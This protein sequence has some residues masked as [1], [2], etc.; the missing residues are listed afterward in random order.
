MANDYAIWIGNLNNEYKEPMIWYGLFQAGSTAA[1]DAGEL[2]TRGGGTYFIPLA[3]DESMAGVIAF[4][5]CDIVAGDLLGY[6]PIIVPRPGDIFKVPI[7]TQ[8]AIALGTSLY[9]A[10]DKTVTTT[11]GSN[12]LGKSARI[13]HYPIDQHHLAEGQLGDKGSTKRTPSDSYAHMTI[14]AA[15]SY[16]A[17]LQG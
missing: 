7:A 11:T 14:T 12:V 15:A 3:A 13:D 4:A 8:S 17:A 1:V 5:A 16:W 6:Y 9:W 2:I 10:S